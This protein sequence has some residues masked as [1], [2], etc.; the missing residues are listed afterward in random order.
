[1]FSQHLL[2]PS[3]IWSKCLSQDHWTNIKKFWKDL[4]IDWV[5][6]LIM[7]CWQCLSNLEKICLARIHQI[8]I[9]MDWLSS[10]QL[11]GINS[12]T[13]PPES[14]YNTQSKIWQHFKVQG[15]ITP[16]KFCL[17]QGW[18]KFFDDFAKGPPWGWCKL[19]KLHFKKS[20]T[21]KSKSRL[22]GDR[23]EWMWQ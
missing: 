8:R 19:V 11:G 2:N 10:A 23:K 20:G 7:F 3:R 4:N 22:K 14:I 13:C 17:H 16:A 6:Q 9:A 5:F 12:S 21:T 15:N 18:T 1:M